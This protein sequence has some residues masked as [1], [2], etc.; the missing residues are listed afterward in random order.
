MYYKKLA[1][2]KIFNCRWTLESFT[3]SHNLNIECWNEKIDQ[4]GEHII[5]LMLPRCPAGIEKMYIM[6]MGLWTQYSI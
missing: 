2:F 3:I 1:A 6:F 5:K 4:H